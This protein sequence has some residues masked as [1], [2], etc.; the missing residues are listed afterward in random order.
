MFAPESAFNVNIS[1]F[2]A[3]RDGESRFSISLASCALHIVCKWKMKI[4]RDITRR[5][6]TG[7]LQISYRLVQLGTDGCQ[8]IVSGQMLASVQIGG[9]QR[10]GMTL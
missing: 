4:R 1:G 8:G 7:K 3:G 10:E 2:V 5:F 9:G 6:Q